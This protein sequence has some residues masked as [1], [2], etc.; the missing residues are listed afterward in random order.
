MG[1]AERMYQVER[2][3]DEIAIGGDPPGNAEGR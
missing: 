1:E 2:A 3:L